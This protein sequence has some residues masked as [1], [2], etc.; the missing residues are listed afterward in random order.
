M[1]R[2]SAKVDS[3]SCPKWTALSETRPDVESIV[4]CC[5]GSGCG[6]LV[7]SRSERRYAAAQVFHPM[8]DG[9]HQ[10]ETPHPRGR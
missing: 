5:A 8:Y 6:L 3:R 9:I 10:V 4:K 2:I 1:M 7:Q